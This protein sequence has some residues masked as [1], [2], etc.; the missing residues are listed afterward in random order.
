MTAVADSRTTRSAWG[1]W[2]AAGLFAVGVAIDA[3]D[4]EPLKLIN[5]TLAFVACLLLAAVRPPRPSGVTVAAAGLLLLAV[6][7]LLYRIFGP[8]L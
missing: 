8:G 2:V 6:V 7:L 4:G 5:T 3:I 1:W